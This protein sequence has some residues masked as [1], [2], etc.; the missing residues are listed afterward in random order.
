MYIIAGLGNPGK[1]Y[2]N[3]RHNLGFSALDKLAEDNGIRL[4]KKK[5]QGICG[6]GRIAGERVLLLKP[7]TYMNL[8]GQSIRAAAV[9]Y[10]VEPSHLIVIYDDFDIPA[11]DLR[12]RPF[13]S[14]GTH[15]GMRSIVSELGTER[16]PR[17]RIG[18]GKKNKGELIGFVI[19]KV[20]KD[21]A[22]QFEEVTEK[23]AEA[24]AC[25]V[26]H[27]VNLA[28]NRYNTRKAKKN[29]EDKTEN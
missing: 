29:R 11:G 20:S 27:D 14:A 18:T 26:K 10:K 25:I 3:T 6:E 4:E 5:F 22:G 23:A 16:F 8:S 19:G 1:K 2:E 28:M 24:A 21:E 9:F 15:N 17:I 12:I 7:Q 13:G